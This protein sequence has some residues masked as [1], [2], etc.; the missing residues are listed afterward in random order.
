MVK[1]NR[2]SAAA[3]ACISTS[4]GK[5]E[6][7]LLEIYYKGSNLKQ[8]ESCTLIYLSANSLTHTCSSSYKRNGLVPSILFATLI[9][10][11]IVKLS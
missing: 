7:I 4:Y 8:K 1:S 10:S 6:F 9:R 5:Q 11:V 3:A 2:T